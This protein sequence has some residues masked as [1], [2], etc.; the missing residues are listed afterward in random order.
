LPL[1]LAIEASTITPLA[2]I[3]IRIRSRSLP[4]SVSCKS[5]SLGISQYLMHSSLVMPES[6]FAESPGGMLGVGLP[7]DP[8]GGE[9]L[10]PEIWGFPGGGL[11]AGLPIGFPPDPAPICDRFGGVTFDRF[12]AGGLTDV[13]LDR[14]FL[15]KSGGGG[16]GFGSDGNGGLNAGVGIGIGIGGRSI[17]LVFGFGFELVFGNGIGVKTDCKP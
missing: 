15:A 3:T 5:L 4:L 16:T 8:V 14:T 11:G 9:V 12:A 6:D 2:L 17:E 13:T 1:D 7:P 10:E